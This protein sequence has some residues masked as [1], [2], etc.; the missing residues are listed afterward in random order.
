MK[1]RDETVHVLG[2]GIVGICTAL[3]LLEKGF[4]VVLIDRNDPA[5]GA[6]HGN[7]GV[8]SPWSCIPQSMPGLWK[9]VPK[10]LIDPNGPLSLRWSYAPR[11]IPWLRRFLNSSAPDSLAKIAA[12]MNA[13]NRPN[14]E[15][16]RQHLKGTGHEELLRDSLYVHAFRN[17]ADADLGK[18]SWRIRAEYGVPMERIEGGDL[19]DIEPEISNEYKAA[20]LIKDQAR[21][22]D[23][24]AIGRV[25]LDKAKGMG[26][27]FRK[28]EIQA[29]RP[30][31]AGWMIDTSHGAIEAQKL[32]IA[33]GAW[34]KRILEPLGY[35]MPLEAERGYHLMFGNPGITLNNSIM[36]VDG[37]FVASSMIDGVRCA[38]TA[39]FAGL[40]TPPNYA[41]AFV[42]KKLAKRLFPRLDTSRV[43]PWM[44]TRPSFPDSLP[45]IGEMPHHPGLFAAFGH[46]HYGLGM[47]PNTGRVVA[48]LVAREPTNIDLRP[49]SITRFS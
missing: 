26:A 29:L 10:W 47:A 17:A 4:D 14:V 39:E 12:G 16:Y 3:S 41:R 13:L 5:S 27:H 18:L 2:A 21:A 44:G 8:I 43:T 15:I 31:E 22:I 32:V 11:M 42:F 48:G 38:G 6:S 24:G 36:D 7:A 1:M 23:P 34:S 30:T 25:L 37:K 45:M 20:I 28:V 40:E 35:K 46:C 33:A 49:Y 19:Q 9:Q